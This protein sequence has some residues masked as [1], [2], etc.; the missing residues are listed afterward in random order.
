MNIV[1]D[2]VIFSKEKQGGISTYWY[3]LIKNYQAAE[4]AFFL[5]EKRA[6]ENM[7]RQK[8]NLKN[9]IP[10][11]HLPLPLARLLPLYYHSKD[12]HFLYHSSFYRKL[13]TK[14]SVC[15]ITTIHDFTHN[16]YSAPLNRALHNYL[17]YGSIK[18]AKGIICI[19]KNTFNDLNKY[20]KPKKG[21]KTAVIYNGV[22]K[23]YRPVGILDSGQNSLLN[24]LKLRDRFLLF[25]GARSH[26]KN[27]S[28]AIQLLEQLPDYQLAVVGNPFKETE[29]TSIGKKILDRIVLATG[30]SNKDLNILYNH[31][32]ALIY[33]SSYEGFGIPIAEAMKAG[34]PVLAL[35]VSSIPEVAGNAGMLFDRLDVA[36]FKKAVKQLEESNC[37]MEIMN[38]G[39]ENAKKFDWQKCFRETEAFYKEVDRL[40]H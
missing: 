34:C 8:L 35:N 6:G 24:K 4:E 15:E 12:S 39:F 2:N 18:R 25:V 17:K 26:Y 30:I 11:F 33:P 29:L 13:I 9:V 40:S 21:Q 14:A 16:R 1:F 27:F 36:A 20:C 32:R 3:E 19:S 7:F 28:F 10:H 23:D 22:S 5:E 38:A 31:A 37:R